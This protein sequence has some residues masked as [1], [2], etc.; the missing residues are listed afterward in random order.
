MSDQ[1][2]QTEQ[3]LVEMK[4]PQMPWPVGCVERVAIVYESYAVPAER[5]QPLQIVAEEFGVPTRELRGWIASPLFQTHLVDA[6]KFVR[7]NHT[8]FRMLAAAGA[9]GALPSVIKIAQDEDQPG[10]T[11]LKAFELLTRAGGV[12]PSEDQ[13]G[14]AGPGGKGVAAIEI[15]FQLQPAEGQQAPAGVVIDAA[16]DH[17]RSLPE[18]ARDH[19]VEKQQARLAELESKVELAK[20]FSIPLPEAH[21]KSNRP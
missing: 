1:S 14:P 4:A 3:A 16:P 5:A 2:S 20:S 19:I 15:R 12:N 9:E 10:S 8:K 18:P 11:R 13:A 21:F 17:A 6:R 7:E